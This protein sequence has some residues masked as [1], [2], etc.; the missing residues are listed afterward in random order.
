MKEK[1][2]LST[3]G[4]VIKL[5]YGQIQSLSFYKCFDIELKSDFKK[6]KSSD[7]SK[8]VIYRSD[9]ANISRM[10]QSIQNVCLHLLTNQNRINIVCWKKDF[11]GIALNLYFVWC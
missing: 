3:F 9:E 4:T 11:E 7:P 1:S 8:N 10:S 6:K 5:F 2:K